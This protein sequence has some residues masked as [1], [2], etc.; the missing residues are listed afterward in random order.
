VIGPE[1]LDELVSG[2]GAALD[3]VVRAPVS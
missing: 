3:A 2:I 1:D